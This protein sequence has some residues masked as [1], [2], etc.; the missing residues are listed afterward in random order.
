MVGANP[1]LLHMAYPSLHPS[2]VQGTRAAE[3]KGCNWACKLTDG[4]SRK[5][6]DATPSVTSSGICHR[7]KSPTL[8]AVASVEEI[9]KFSKLNEN[10][11]LQETS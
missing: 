10:V 2:G 1:E 7:N 8:Y 3:H 9:N 4:C 6:C 5:S 11:D